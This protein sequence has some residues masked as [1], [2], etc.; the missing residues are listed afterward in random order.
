MNVHAVLR[1]EQLFFAYGDDED[2]VNDAAQI[3]ARSLHTE[4]WRNRNR[5]RDQNYKITNILTINDDDPLQESPSRRKEERRRNQQEEYFQTS[6]WDRVPVNIDNNNKD[7]GILI[8][9]SVQD[10]VCFISTGNAISTFLPWWRLEHVVASMK[11]DLRH[12]DYGGAI[13][14]AIDELSEMLEVGPPTFKDMALDIMTRFGIVLGFAVFTFLFGVYGECR[15]KRKRWE[16]A[17][18]RSLLNSVELEKARLKQKEFQTKECPICLEPFT[19]E[20]CEYDDD[21]ETKATADQPPIEAKRTCGMVGVDAYRIPLKG[22][23]SKNIKFLRCGHILCESCWKAYIRSGHGN[24]S[25]CPVCRQDVGKSSSKKRRNREQRRAARRA[26]RE[27]AA[28]EAAASNPASAAA[29]T[30]RTWLVGG[31]EPLTLGG[32]GYAIPA[33]GSLNDASDPTSALSS[34]QTGTDE[35]GDSNESSGDDEH[36]SIFDVGVNIFASAFGSIRNSGTINPDQ[37]GEGSSDLSTSGFGSF[38]GWT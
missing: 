19:G 3:F 33:Y 7:F 15:D 17:E 38:E 23:D 2:M 5:N 21:D 6:G 16:Y 9:L 34:S 22:A 1:E 37:S 25:M 30:E 29:S 28:A 20:E 14:T 11:P 24:P 10:H 27:A 13:L 31:G 8:F 4:W 12:R 35:N 18:S 36:E 26:R 32:T